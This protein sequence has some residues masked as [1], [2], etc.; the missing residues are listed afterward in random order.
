[1]QTVRAANYT[2]YKLFDKT[3]SHPCPYQCDRS[4]ELVRKAQ[5]LQE[6]NRFACLLT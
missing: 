5:Y 1:M 3:D 2:N 6:I 4:Q